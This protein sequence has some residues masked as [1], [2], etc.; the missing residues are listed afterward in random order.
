MKC[1]E[2]HSDYMSKQ[3][4]INHV[5][6][7][8]YSLGLSLFYLYYRSNTASTICDHSNKPSPSLYITIM[9]I[10]N[11]RNNDENNRVSDYNNKINN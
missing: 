7:G 9:K 5:F 11:W 10:I 6:L 3:V 4:L 8:I 2:I 1:R